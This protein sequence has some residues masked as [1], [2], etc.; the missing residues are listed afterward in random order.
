MEYIRKQRWANYHSLKCKEYLRNDFSHECAYCKLQ[1]NEVGFVSEDFFEIDHFK[2]QAKTPEDLHKY[3][4]LY[5]CCQKC[6]GEKS[7]H[8]SDKLLDPCRDNIF[9][10]PDPAIIGGDAKKGFIFEA[11]NDRGTLYIDTFKLNSRRQIDIRRMRSDNKNKI[12]EINEL[13]DKMTKII[14]SDS[15][16]SH[17]SYLVE[18]L[19]E[20]RKIKQIETDK[21]RRNPIFE[22]A[23]EYLT[24]RGIQHSL[25]FQELNLDFEI[26]IENKTYLCELIID[27]STEIKE[28]YNK[29]IE[30]EKI[31][32]W[33]SIP[34]IKFGVL[35]YYPKIERMYFLKLSDVLSK[36]DIDCDLNSKQFTISNENL[37]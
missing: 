23:Q 36:T 18:Q 20:L 1:E 28:T 25:V 29:K 10:G 21:L 9:S 2:P 32:A 26:K 27:N 35:F 22:Q 15:N 13:I 12:K 24:S 7:D 33:F 6:N 37:L 5:Y 19:T 30:T 4:N 31:L 11:A 17:L 14:C 8:W 16:L 3:P 34:N